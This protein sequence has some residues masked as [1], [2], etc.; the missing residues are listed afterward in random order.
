MA[1]IAI[2]YRYP[3]WSEGRQPHTPG[4]K[5]GP[6]SH[7]ELGP[8]HVR[9]WPT[10]FPVCLYGLGGMPRQVIG[11]SAPVVNNRL[12]Q[13]QPQWWTTIPGIMKYPVSSPN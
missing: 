10:S 3:G 4:Q 2:P 13:V 9:P 7:M 12:S 11:P 1:N 8:S 5:G 6:Q